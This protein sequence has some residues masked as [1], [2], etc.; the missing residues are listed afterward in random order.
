M[1]ETSPFLFTGGST[2]PAGPV[3][4]KP[5]A[6]RQIWTTALGTAAGIILA[7]VVMAAAVL[8]GFGTLIGATLSGSDDAAGTVGEVISGTGLSGDELERCLRDSSTC[9]AP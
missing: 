9:P 6:W 4:T 2:R 7:I 8:L 5:P 1:A 3:A